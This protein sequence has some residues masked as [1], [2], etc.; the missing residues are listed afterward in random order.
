MGR[1]RGE[2]VQHE[3]DFIGGDRESCVG[4]G[5]VGRGQGTGLDVV[6]WTWYT[7]QAV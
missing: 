2:E 7:E 1:H 5:E 6:P 3:F 4:C